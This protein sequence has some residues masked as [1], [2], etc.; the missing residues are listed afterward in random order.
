[1]M[2]R[3]FTVGAC[4]VITVAAV[5][6]GGLAGPSRA[7]TYGSECETLPST[8]HVAKEEFDDAGRLVRT[9]EEDLAVNKCEGACVSKVQPSV[10]TPSGFLK[11]CRCCRETHLRARDVVLTHCYDGDGNR[12]TGDNGKLTVKLRE[13]ADCQCFKCGNSIR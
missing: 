8:I 1:M 9:C 7:H 5:V 12:I 11:D 3:P 10:N 2:P 6:V 4:V 13:P